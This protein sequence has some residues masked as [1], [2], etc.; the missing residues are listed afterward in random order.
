MH[1]QMCILKISLWWARQDN[2]KNI[3]VRGGGVT[4]LG[5]MNRGGQHSTMNQ[6]GQEVKGELKRG[7]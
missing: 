7:H 2:K 4:G 1:R 3:R 5:E 6:Q